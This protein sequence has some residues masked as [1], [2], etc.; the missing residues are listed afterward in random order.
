MSIERNAEQRRGILSTLTIAQMRNPNMNDNEW[1][2]FFD[3]LRKIAD[4]PDSTW[5]EK[6]QA[7]RDEAAQ[8]GVD[9]TLEEFLEW[10]D[11]DKDVD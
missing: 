6:R 2:E 4:L 11:G 3:L 5:Q 1:D 10:F 9:T 8:R 7:V